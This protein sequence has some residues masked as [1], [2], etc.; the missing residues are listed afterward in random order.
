MSNVIDRIRNS[1]VCQAWKEA[2]SEAR[3]MW[4]VALAV[5]A[6]VVGMILFFAPEMEAWQKEV[7]IIGISYF[8]IRWYRVII[9]N[10]SPHGI[11]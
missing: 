9:M 5:M 8:L 7:I 6:F 11:I 1:T 2:H 10:K 4:L 3:Q